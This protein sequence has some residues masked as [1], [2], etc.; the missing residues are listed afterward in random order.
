M[1]AQYRVEG[2]RLINITNGGEAVMLG[3]KHR[4]E[5]I[6]LMR[7]I[8]AGPLNGNYGKKLSPEKCALLS[9]NRKG[10]RAWNKGKMLSLEHRIA[11]SKAH[12][13]KPAWN[14]GIKIGKPAWNSGKSRFEADAIC[15]LKSEGLTQT[16]IAK[17][18]G[19]DQGTISRIVRGVKRDCSRIPLA[20]RI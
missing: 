20:E 11:L 4:P 13:G 5:T 18:V 2:K 16:E 10:R 9:V 17:I 14:S 12:I 3:R 15:R 7:K 8:H 6:D 19:T 1:I